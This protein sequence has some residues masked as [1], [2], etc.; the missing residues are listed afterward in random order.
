M[1]FWALR[2][3]ICVLITRRNALAGLCRLPPEIGVHIVSLLVNSQPA[4]DPFHTS[5]HQAYALP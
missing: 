5:A 3:E 1:R 4:E 2:E